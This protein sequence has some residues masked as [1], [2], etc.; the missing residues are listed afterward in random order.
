MVEGKKEERK[1]FIFN[2][3]E[4][5]AYEKEKKRKETEAGKSRTPPWNQLQ[6]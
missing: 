1:M 2:E 4:E 3:K 6:W 5:K